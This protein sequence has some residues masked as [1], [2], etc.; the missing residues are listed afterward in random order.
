MPSHRKK[1][2]FQVVAYNVENLFD[3]DGISLYDDY[4]PGMY[5]PSE[6]GNKLQAI[7]NT[8]KKIGGKNGPEVILFQEIEVDRTPE[9]IL[10]AS[11]ELLRELK[12]NGM[13][14]YY[15]E[16]GY[17]LNGLPEIGPLFIASRSP[18]FQLS[19]ANFMQLNGLVPFLKPQSM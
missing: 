15:Y 8:L 2:S 17:D 6:L 19:R 13:G 12:L 11:D 1:K 18:N 7:V 10:S 5:G 9:K 14:P 3:L 16:L 4:K